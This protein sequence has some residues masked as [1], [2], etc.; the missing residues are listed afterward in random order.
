MAPS[1]ASEERAAWGPINKRSHM[2]IRGIALL[3]VGCTFA[4][5]G[6]AVLVR[7]ADEP[8]RRGDR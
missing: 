5:T 7:R 1:R 2:R 4:F 6:V 3:A 8:G